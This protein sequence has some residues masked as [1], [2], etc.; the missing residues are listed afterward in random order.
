MTL[1]FGWWDHFE[2]RS[3]MPLWQQMTRLFSAD[4]PKDFFVISPFH[5]ADAELFGRFIRTWP[6]AKV[7]VLGQQGYTTLPV[8]AS[9]TCSSCSP[10]F[11]PWP[12]VHRSCQGNSLLCRKVS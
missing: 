1:Q 5:D 7:E 3:D 6:D 12:S 10:A 11:G 4:K 9:W 2:Q 8:E